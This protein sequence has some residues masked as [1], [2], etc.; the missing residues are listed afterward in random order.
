[1][2]IWGSASQ[3]S[4]DKLQVSLWVL[5][6]CQVPSPQAMEEPSEWAPVGKQFLQ[7]MLGFRFLCY[8]PLP[9]SQF[10]WDTK[11]LSHINWHALFRRACVTHNWFLSM[12]TSWGD[13]IFIN[14]IFR[15]KTRNDA[16]D[17]SWFSMHANPVKFN[18]WE[19]VPQGLG[20]LSQKG[21]CAH[22]PSFLRTAGWA[23]DDW[24]RSLCLW[25]KHPMSIPIPSK[26]PNF[27]GN[28]KY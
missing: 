24:L 11:L 7:K 23:P 22:V 9:S 2:V 20:S 27:S 4:D 16:S 17:F 6:G 1:M 3:R 19:T 8:I 21:S 15:S 12:S 5:R 28:S 14:F 25:Q 13:W 18:C 26:M 10:L